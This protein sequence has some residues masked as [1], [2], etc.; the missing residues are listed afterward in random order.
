VLDDLFGSPTPEAVPVYS[1]DDVRKP[2]LARPVATLT[3]TDAPVLLGDKGGGR[4]KKV[5]AGVGL[6]FPEMMGA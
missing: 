2:D 6:L 1:L 5:A 3:F 4:R